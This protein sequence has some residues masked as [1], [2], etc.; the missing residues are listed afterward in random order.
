LLMNPIVG[1]IP[2][3]DAPASAKAAQVIG[4]V[5]ERPFM[6]LSREVPIR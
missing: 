6:S 4:I 2:I 1:G 3:I 5:F